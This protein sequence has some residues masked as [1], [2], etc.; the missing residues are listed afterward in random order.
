MCFVFANILEEI[1]AGTEYFL[2]ERLQIS[3]IF[4][5]FVPEIHIHLYCSRW[6][7]AW[8]QLSLTAQNIALAA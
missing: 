1:F 7:Q 5:I 6:W 4:I 8:E 2:P 3:N